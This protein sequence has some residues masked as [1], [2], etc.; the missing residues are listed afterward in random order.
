MFVKLLVTLFVIFAL[1][2]VWLRRRDGSINF[3]G[4]LAWSVVW[5]GVG[6][7]VWLPKISDVAAG[8]IGIGRGVDA[9]VYFSIIVLYY[10]AFRLYIKLELL[11]RDLTALVRALALRNRER[12]I[13]RDP[14]KVS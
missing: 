9:L 10:G 13:E 4:W 12:A 3:G 2:R 7:F 5:V 1:S 14:P 8:K 11:Q 6:V